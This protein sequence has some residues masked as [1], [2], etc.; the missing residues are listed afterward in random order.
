MPPFVLATLA[1]VPEASG[2]SYFLA[3]GPEA[4][5]A[6]HAWS[7]TL[8]VV[9]HLAG[10][11]AGYAYRFRPTFAYELLK[12]GVSIEDV[13]VVLGHRSIRVTPICL[14]PWRP[15]RQHRLDAAVRRSWAFSE[16][17]ARKV[18]QAAGGDGQDIRA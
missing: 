11:R 7:Q 9:F 15:A 10:I 16:K 6:I 14:L 3:D 4:H 2:R 17:V 1:A 5:S 18:L 13:S 12:A 8:R